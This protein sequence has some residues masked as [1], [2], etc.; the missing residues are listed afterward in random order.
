MIQ[1][2]NGKNRGGE[3]V[4]PK[5]RWKGRFD[6]ASHAQIGL[7]VCWAI[8]V[9]LLTVVCGSVHANAETP[10]SLNNSGPSIFRGEI[11]KGLKIEMKLYQDGSSLY[12]TYSYEAFGRDIQVKGTVNQRGEF[13]L[14]EFVKG[15]LTG[16]FKGKF[17][18]MD[19]VEGKWFKK[20]PSETG[21]S[22]YMVRTGA[23]LAAAQTSASPKPG[24][25]ASE[26]SPAPKEKPSVPKPEATAKPAPMPIETHPQ[27]LS[28]VKQASAPVAREVP[29]AAQPQSKTEPK[30]QPLERASPP[31][32]SPLKIEP[33]QPPS[34][35]QVALSPKAAEEPPK[36]A[37]TT[38][39]RPDEK[40]HVVGRAVNSTER[41][42]SSS[43]ADFFFNL[44][45]GGAIG[46]IILL[47][48]GLAWLAI[49]A[50]GAAA[51]RENSALFREAH[52]M[53]ISFL[54]GFFL[55]A[56]GVGAVLAVF[57]E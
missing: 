3:Q 20:S 43:W 52:A 48:G 37:P 42:G 36:V 14:Q 19:R 29:V 31:Q 4:M 17:V 9:G 47:G 15:N 56:L 57:V 53:G 55:L 40:P 12:G 50:G 7:V 41:K 16:T 32:Q 11:A 54:P 21:R 35:G 5:L 28:G 8:I 34:T 10:S 2:I 44:K 46:G 24:G 33:V 1:A 25:G 22:F 30:V 6:Q 49:V 27:T 13:A 45:V 18:T 39:M 38:E 26:T 51:F 23:P